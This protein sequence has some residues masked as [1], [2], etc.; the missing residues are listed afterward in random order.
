L[1]ACHYDTLWHL[2]FKLRICFEYLLEDR[3][4]LLYFDNEVNGVTA[5]LVRINNHS[6]DLLD[7][8]LFKLL[9][10]L[11][12]NLTQYLDLLGK[13]VKISSEPPIVLTL[14][15]HLTKFDEQLLLML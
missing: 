1:D 13:L 7:V 15:L 6:L 4:C 8:L 12:V 3:A 2:L 5:A 14:V 9:V 11:W 10:N